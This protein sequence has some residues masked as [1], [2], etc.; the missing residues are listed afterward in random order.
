MSDEYKRNPIEATLKAR[1]RDVLMSVL[2]ARLRK[3]GGLE[4]VRS[5]GNQF[6]LTY[7]I[8]VQGHYKTRVFCEDFRDALNWVLDYLAGDVELPPDSDE[9][10][11]WMREL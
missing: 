2:N 8:K 10:S 1:E 3:R 7:R 6:E 11:N 5:D 9:A 4:L